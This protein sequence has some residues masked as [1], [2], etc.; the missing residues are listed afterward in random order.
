MASSIAIAQGIG[1]IDWSLQER[2]FVDEMR[3]LYEKQGMPLSDEQAQTAVKQLRDRQKASHKGIPSSEW[4]SQEIALV[5]RYR[6]VYGKQGLPF[7]DEQGAL[8]V[9]SMREQM[10]RF[11]GGMAAVQ[12]LSSQR[13]PM[14]ATNMQAPLPIASSIPIANNTPISEDQL[15]AQLARLPPKAGDLSLKQRREGFVVN[16]QPVVDAEGRITMY[17]YD[18]STGDITYAVET[19]TN[20][21]IKVMRA[22]SGMPAIVIATAIKGQTGWNVQTVTGQRLA[23]PALSMMPC[24]LLVARP[25][26]AFRYEPGQGVR[27]IAIPDGYV[28][29][30]IQR[31]NV[32]ATGY[33]LLEKENAN[34]GSNEL[35]QLFSSV[36]ALGAGLGMNKKED[37]ALYNIDTGATFPLNIE[38][39]GR[40]VTVLSDCYRRKPNSLVNECYRAQSFESLYDKMGERN[41]WHYY[42]RVHWLKT[43]RGPIAITMENGSK[44]IFITDLG[45]RKK[46]SAFHRTLGINELDVIQKPDGAVQID[47]RLAFDR[48]TI[49]DAIAYLTST[50]PVGQEAALTPE[51]RP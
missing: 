18:V 33:L 22:G 20:T 31:G 16:G 48:Q 4:T 32:G 34:G 23:G 8:A 28:L 39:E 1:P 44:D 42:W 47:A 36:K 27:N 50:S 2:Q 37:Y 6:E 17:G 25:G 45:T 43:P 15:A 40:N 12:N 21:V 7:T 24:G 30:P 29:T 19:P 41:T 10:A 46:V 38:A 13:M 11:T 5:A 14:Q 9:Q 51:K 3:A 49:P 26:A 35:S